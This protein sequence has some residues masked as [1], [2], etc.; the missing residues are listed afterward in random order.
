MII[1]L[2]NQEFEIQSNITLIELKN[3]VYEKFGVYQ[4][5]Q[6]IR[7][8]SNYITNNKFRFNKNHDK[9]CIIIFIKMY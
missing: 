3:I 5:H 4:E 9:S 7:V 1:K 2:N 8:E 6:L